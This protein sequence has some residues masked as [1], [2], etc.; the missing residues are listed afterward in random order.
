MTNIITNEN[1]IGIML[2]EK[3]ESNVKINPVVWVKTV[4]T[5]YYETACGSGSLA[6]GIYNYAQN[7]VKIVYLLQPSGYKIRVE[8]NCEGKQ[9]IKAKVSGVVNLS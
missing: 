1:A 5:L 9:I 2:I 6:Y 8:L 7:G 4:D 3:V